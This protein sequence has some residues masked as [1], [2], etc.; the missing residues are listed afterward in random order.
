[1]I[2]DNPHIQGAFFKAL[3]Y[4]D[5]TKNIVVSVSG[6]SDSDIITD[7][8]HQCDYTDQVNFIFIDTGLEYQA[9]KD[10]IRDLEKKYQIRINRIKAYKSI[11]N[12]VKQFGTPFLSKFIS[13]NIERLQKHGFKWENKPY[14]ELIKVYPGCKS[15]LKWW[16]NNHDR[17]QWNINYKKYLKEFLTENPPDFKISAKC[18]EYAKKK[19]A[20]DYYR[21]NKTDIVITGLRL[22]EG[23]ARATAY[24]SCYSTAT[25]DN[26]RPIWW[27]SDDDK[28]EYARFYGVKYS[29]CY[30]EYGFKRTGCACCPFGLGL[31]GELKKTARHEPKLYRA[32]M[33][34]FGKS[35]EYTRLYYQYRANLENQHA[36][37]IRKTPALDLYGGI[38]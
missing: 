38:A 4:L 35:Y 31:E 37:E 24:K 22:S 6:G 15:A 7:F 13:E 30:S 28:R 5:F 25:P 19:T 36:R 11:P 34:V 27:F 21:K 33:S 32:V 18:C 26:Y 12:C 17:P 10:H 8:I 14:N 29:R 20:K 9:T 16:T 2:P 1:M 23:G 3:G